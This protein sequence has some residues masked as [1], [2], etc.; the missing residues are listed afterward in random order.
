MGAETTSKYNHV[1]PQNMASNITENN[2]PEHLF[3]YMEYHHYD[4]IIDAIDICPFDMESCG[5]DYEQ[6]QSMVWVAHA[7]INPKTQRT[8]LEEVAG[9]HV[10]NEKLAA[11]LARGREIVLDEFEAI[12]DDDDTNIIALKASQGGK[13]YKVRTKYIMKSM[14]MNSGRIVAAI[15]PWYAKNI[16]KFLGQV[17]ILPDK[18]SQSTLCNIICIS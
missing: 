18:N 10:K 1:K 2:Y 14:F 4:Q 16:Y 8:I 12:T 15:K 7:W 11:K 5:T 6:T 3:A 13:I 17:K 9:K